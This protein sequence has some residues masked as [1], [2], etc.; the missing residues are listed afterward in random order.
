MSL[1]PQE[2]DRKIDEHF[3]FEARDDIEGVLDT[4]AEDATHDV[5]GWP[6]GPSHGR[7]EARR[8]YEAL[9]SDLAESK[10]TCTRRLHGDGFLVDESVWE[11]KAP[12]QPFGLPGKNRPLRFRLLHVLEFTG[13]GEIQKE[14]VWLDLA[15]IIQQLGED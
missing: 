8:F 2:M 11:G 10:V 6:A 13:T 12:G 9:F 5:V 7:Q 14:Q 3:G 1:T 15:A 4:L